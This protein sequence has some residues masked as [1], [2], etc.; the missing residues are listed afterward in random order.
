MRR[1]WTNQQLWAQRDRNKARSFARRRTA[2]Y[3]NICA[4]KAKQEG[5]EEGW[6]E[7]ETE[8]VCIPFGLDIGSLTQ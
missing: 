3:K 2:V 4:T 1:K 5:R 6:E 8:S 7:E